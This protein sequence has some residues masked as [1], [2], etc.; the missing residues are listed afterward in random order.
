MSFIWLL[1]L[2]C[3]IQT[4]EAEPLNHHSSNRCRSK[5]SGSTPACWNDK[6]WE[7]FCERVTCKPEPVNCWNEFLQ[8][9]RSTYPTENR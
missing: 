2:A 9:E 1:I 4:K 5:L 6:D 7:A 8:C 3:D